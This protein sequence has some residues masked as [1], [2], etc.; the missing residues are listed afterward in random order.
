M[1]RA[2]PRGKKPRPQKPP[3]LVRT[4]TLTQTDQATLDRLSKDM[5]DYTGRT[6][7][8]SAI[9]RALIR[10]ASQQ[11]ATWALSQL[12]PFVEQEL[13]I[14]LLWGKQK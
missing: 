13:S 1:A 6:I 3:L 5:S 2:T 8:G 4:I 12:A 10:Y 7:S 11:P 9:V 14:G